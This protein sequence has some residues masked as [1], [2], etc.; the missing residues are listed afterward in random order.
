M[1]QLP[2]L[3]SLTVRLT[4]TADTAHTADIV[5]YAERYHT[6]AGSGTAM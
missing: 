2:L 4:T 3:K 6:T 5:Q 1:P